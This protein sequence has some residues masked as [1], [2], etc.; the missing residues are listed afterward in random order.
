[1]AKP[2]HKWTEAQLARLEQLW[3]QKIEMRVLCAAVGV[4][5]YLVYQKAAELKLPRRRVSRIKRETPIAGRTAA[6]MRFNKDGGALAD[7]S[8]QAR[9]SSDAWATQELIARYTALAE[10]VRTSA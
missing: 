3:P 7:P 9:L 2:A 1:M 10:R 5:Q 6:P 4:S 8:D